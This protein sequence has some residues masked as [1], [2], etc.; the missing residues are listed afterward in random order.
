MSLVRLALLCIVLLFYITMSSARGGWAQNTPA[1]PFLDENPF[2]PSSTSREAVVEAAL[3]DYA[4]TSPSTTGAF[5]SPQTVSPGVVSS[6]SSGSPSRQRLQEVPLQDV[7]PSSSTVGAWGANGS[8]ARAFETTTLSPTSEPKPSKGFSRFL[9]SGAGK[10]NT[11]GSAGSPSASS[12]INIA[13]LQ[14]REAEMR[15]R[16]AEVAKREA[17]VGGLELK[18]KNFPRQGWLPF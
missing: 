11:K 5:G 14:R 10:E 15:R 7:P 6:A 17:A 9:S 3:R 4:G 8:S 1:N 16:E 12:S 18:R 2:Q 13:D